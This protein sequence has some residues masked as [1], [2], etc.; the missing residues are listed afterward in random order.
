MDWAIS[1]DAK[2]SRDILLRRPGKGLRGALKMANDLDK[3]CC[4]G[5]TTCG[6]KG[7]EEDGV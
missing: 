7:S 4:V 5:K 2:E 1:R 6:M 3:S